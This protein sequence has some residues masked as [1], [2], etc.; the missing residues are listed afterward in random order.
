MRDA[1]M[2]AASINSSRVPEP[3]RAP[4]ALRDP[5]RQAGSGQRLE[6]GGAEPAPG[7]RWPGRRRR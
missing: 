2:P 4:T 7:R 6:P 5:Q 3:G 1:E